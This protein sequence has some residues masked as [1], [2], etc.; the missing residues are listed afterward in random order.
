MLIQSTKDKRVYK[1]LTSNIARRLKQHS[2]GKNSSTKHYRPWKLIYFE[3]YHTRSKARL[4][5]KY[6]KSGQGRDEI[7]KIVSNKAGVAELVDA[8]A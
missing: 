5:E 7:R 3:E 2:S 4:R 6:F 8:Y 1:R